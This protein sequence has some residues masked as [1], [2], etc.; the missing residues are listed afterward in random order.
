MTAIETTMGFQNTSLEERPRVF[1][2][3]VDLNSHTQ[4]HS[5]HRNYEKTNLILINQL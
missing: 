2:N 3:K 4:Q 1:A 5:L